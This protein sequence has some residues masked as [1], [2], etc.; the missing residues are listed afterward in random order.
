MMI[1]LFDY[2]DNQMIVIF[3]LLSESFNFK[4][5]SKKRELISSEKTMSSFVIL[6]K[7]VLCVKTSLLSYIK[8]IAFSEVLLSDFLKSLSL[9]LLKINLLLSTFL[10]LS[11]ADISMCLRCFKILR[12][13]VFI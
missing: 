12:T 7:S 1:V 11:L 5:K 8:L 10:I 13:D 2:S 9:I 3:F 4:K 6:E